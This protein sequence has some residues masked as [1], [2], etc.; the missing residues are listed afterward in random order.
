MIDRLK[1]IDLFLKEL[2]KE[3]EEYR[4]KSNVYGA[5]VKYDYTDEEMAAEKIDE[6]EYYDTVWMANN[7]RHWFYEAINDNG[8]YQFNNRI[9]L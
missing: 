1:E 9:L 2:A 5:L 6:R 7:I 4:K 3:P 8:F